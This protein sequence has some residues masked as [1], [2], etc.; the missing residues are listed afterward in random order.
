MTSLRA[1]SSTWQRYGFWLPLGRLG[2]VGIT[3]LVLLLFVSGVPARYAQIVQTADKRSLYELGVSTSLY[4]IYVLTLSFIPVLFHNIIAAVIFWRRR[5]DW[6]ALLLSYALVAN[7]AIIPLSVMN[8]QTELPAIQHFL[9]RAVISVG[10]ISSVSLLYLFPDGSF[11]PGWTRFLAFAWA[12]IVLMAIFF[13]ESSLSLANW[14]LLLQIMVLLVW[15]G[16]GIYVQAYRYF[17]VSSPLQ[18]QQSKWALFGLIAAVFSPF[19]YFLPFVILPSINEPLVPN[20]LYRRVGTSFFTI[21][22]LVRLSGMTLSSMALLLFP[23]SFAIAVLR[24]RLWDIDVLIRRTLIYLCLT[25]SL[26]L[27][28]F[29]SVVFFQVFLRTFTGQTSSLAVVISTLA[30]A[31]LFNPLRG[32]VQN[33]IDRRFYRRK[34]DAEKT[35]AAFSVTLRDEVDLRT[36]SEDLLAVVKETMQPESVSLWLRTPK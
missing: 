24:Y 17:N 13:R 32:G 8:A 12:A 18:R 11:V 29:S 14:P 7:G 31:A 22:L 19:V 9:I 5:R 33:E 30:I 15:T 3:L 27:I 2:W 20:L 16:I 26:I 10:L 34:Y 1:Q 4:A 6:M 36:L 35:L 23:I 21:S 25:V 28:Y